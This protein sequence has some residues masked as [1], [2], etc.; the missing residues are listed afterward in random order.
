MKVP[1]LVAVAALTVLSGCASAHDAEARG[2]RPGA[3]GTASGRPSPAASLPPE[4]PAPGDHALAFL[5]PDGARVNFVLH[6]PPGYAPGRAYPLVLV[7]HGRPGTAAGMPEQ[8]GMNPVAD[9]HGFLVVYPDQVFDVDT[10]T[11]LI[12][13]LIPAWGVDVERIHAAGFSRGASLVYELARRSTARFGSVAPVSGVD[14]S[15]APLTRPISLITFQGGVDR[16]SASFGRTNAKW[17]EAAKCAGGKLTSITMA[18]GPTHVRRMTC[19]G[20]TEH[21]VYD[22]TRMGHAWPAGASQLIWEFFSRHPLG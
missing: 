18:G 14:D 6:A 20:G 13:H 5:K 9:E 1:I 16:L 4:N 8:T 7:F 21:T 11:A 2:G 10:A 12:D 15:G 17:D 3:A 22:V 19:A